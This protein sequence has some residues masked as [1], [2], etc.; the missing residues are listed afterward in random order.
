MKIKRLRRNIT[1]NLLASFLLI[2]IAIGIFFYTI[3]Q[4]EVAT[5]ELN[6]IRTEASIIRGQTQDLESQGND[7]KKYKETWKTI[8]NNKKNTQ[9]IKMEEVN[10]TLNTLADKY[11]IYSPSLQVLLPENLESGVF[12]RKTLI[13]SHSSGTL[14]FETLSDVRALTFIADF[15]NKLPGYIVITSLEIGKLRKY[16]NEDFINISLGKNPGILRVKI[17]FSWYVYRDQ[18]KKY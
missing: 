10:N 2:I 5:Q 4:D 9:G 6:K 3:N 17:N 15:F 12:Q 16:S 18:D 13:V 8:S 11:G 1:I 14:N 7:A